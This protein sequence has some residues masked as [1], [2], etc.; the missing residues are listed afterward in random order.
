MHFADFYLCTSS[1]LEQNVNSL[2]Y[3]SP[4]MNPATTIGFFVSWFVQFLEVYTYFILFIAVSLM[5][6][7]FCSYPN[8]IVQDFQM[9]M[10]EN[11]RFSL[12]LFH[13]IEVQWHNEQVKAM[14]ITAVQLHIKLIRWVTIK[15]KSLSTAKINMLIQVFSTAYDFVFFFQING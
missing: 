3:S 11:E 1:S 4:T 9:L 13:R 14:H 12:N 2:E 7:G 10:T 6:I 5:H 8:A 15:E